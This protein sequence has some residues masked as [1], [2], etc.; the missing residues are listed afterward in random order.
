MENI[1][2][3]EQ[4]TKKFGKKTAV[5]GVSLT[6]EKGTTVA[7]L[8]PNGAGKTTTISMML[9]LLEPTSGTVKVFDKSPK[10]IAVRNR[11]GAMLQETS[12]LDMLKVR[13]FIEMFRSYYTSPLSMEELIALTGFKEDELKKRANKLSGGQKRRLGFALALA[14]NPDLI[15]FDEPTVGLDITARR[16]FWERVEIL[17]LQGKTIIFTTH[18]LQ[19]ADDFSERIILFNNGEIITDGKPDEIKRNI[20]TRSVSFQTD[21]KEVIGLLQSFDDVIRCYE[22]DGRIYVVTSNTDAVIAGIF[23]HGVDANDIAIEQ[24]RLEEVFEHLTSGSKEAI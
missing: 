15:F 22:K 18:Y 4:V 5:N 23:R 20:A 2:K 7:I 14:G 19:E 10:E 11:I 16:N 8:G 13:E 1:V 24:G 3:L 12:V 6:I 21:D 9:G 17:K